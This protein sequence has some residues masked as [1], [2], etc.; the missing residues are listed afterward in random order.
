MATILL[1]VALA[2]GWLD[3]EAFNVFQIMLMFVGTLAFDA[4]FS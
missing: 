4:V 1:I 2:F 3:Y